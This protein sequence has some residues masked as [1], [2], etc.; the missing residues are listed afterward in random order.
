[1]GMREREP[2]AVWRAA[3]QA[4]R[5]LAAERGRPVEVLDPGPNR[6]GGTGCTVRH[7][8]DGAELLVIATR[9]TSKRVPH[10]RTVRRWLVAMWGDFR[11][12]PPETWEYQGNTV[13]ILATDP[14]APE[15]PTGGEA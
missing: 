14:P 4:A 7:Y 8:G 10:R 12:Y 9:G 3:C 6:R 11:P 2:D 5:E 15:P 1:M 13:R